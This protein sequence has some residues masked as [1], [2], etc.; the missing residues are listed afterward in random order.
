MGGPCPAWPSGGIRFDWI[1]VG[2]LCIKL[3]LSCDP[4]FHREILAAVRCRAGSGSPLTSHT[5]SASIHF[6][7]ALML[8]LMTPC[9]KSLQIIIIK[10]EWEIHLFAC[11]YVLHHNLYTTTLDPS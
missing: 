11:F 3:R 9:V 5:L 7:S 2:D 8:S 4:A 1:G 10:N 6:C